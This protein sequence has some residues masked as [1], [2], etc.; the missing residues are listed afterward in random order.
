MSNNMLRA[1]LIKS[2]VLLAVFS[3]LVYLT[4]TSPDGSV[5][6][7]LGKIFLV[8]FKAAQLGVGLVLALVLCFVVLG[9]I[10]FGG[11][12]LMSRESAA[13]MY[14]Q[15]CQVISGKLL[16]LKSLVKRDGQA[17]SAV[18][19]DALGVRLK[20]EVFGE[21]QDSLQSVRSSL[22]TNEERYDDLRGRVELVERMD[23]SQVLTERLG[24]LQEKVELLADQLQ[25]LQEDG[26]VVELSGR[27]ENCES[28]LKKNEINVQDI[29]LQV[30]SLR[31]DVAGISVTP[32]T[33]EG[34]TLKAVTLADGVEKDP[35]LF[36]Y[37]DDPKVRHKIEQLLAKTLKQD[38]TYAQAI[39]Y[40]V[41]NIDTK[42]GKILTAHPSLTKEYIRD[43]R[44]KS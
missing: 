15:I 1:P 29:V 23:T 21:V 5:W 14:D 13:R 16:Y 30:G 11:L 28:V 40:L 8:L 34:E 20:S 33:E 37:L 3:L 12:A 17:S 43:R 39:D 36:A 10:F 25:T 6:D 44:K 2:A 4:A 32:V 19:L 41:K 26:S 24:H 9:G 27:I 31:D 38:M 7:S 42:T 18:S 35:R 22:S